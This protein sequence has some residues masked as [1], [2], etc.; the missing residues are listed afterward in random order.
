[1]GCAIDC[2]QGGRGGKGGGRRGRGPWGAG[3]GV[4][5]EPLANKYRA[6]NWHVLE[7]NGNDIPAFIAAV[8][9]AKTIAEKPT[10]ILA[11]TVPGEGVPEIEGDYHWHG[12]PPTKEEGERFLKQIQHA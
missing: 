12:K 4:A 7:V 6:F 1:M 8:E 5:G 11:H 10:M 2:R 3:G 9:E